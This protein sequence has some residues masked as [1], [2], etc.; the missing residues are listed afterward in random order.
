MCDCCLSYAFVYLRSR[1]L[2]AHLMRK[3]KVSLALVI[4]LISSW[5]NQLYKLFSSKKCYICLFESL[6]WTRKFSLIP[7]HCLWNGIQVHTFASKFLNYKQG[8][9]LVL[10]NFPSELNQINT[11]SQHYHYKNIGHWSL[12]WATISDCGIPYTAKPKY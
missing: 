7:K 9:E 3:R 6:T 10:C 4:I 8:V 12:S 2:S 5:L 11:Q 1:G